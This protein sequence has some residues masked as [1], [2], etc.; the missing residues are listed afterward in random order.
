MNYNFFTF[1]VALTVFFNATNVLGQKKV[2]PY[3]CGFI[4]KDLSELTN[5]YQNL[6]RHLGVQNGEMVASVGAS[7]DEFTKSKL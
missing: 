7:N 5:N 3:K 2:R 4:S 6:A 1:I